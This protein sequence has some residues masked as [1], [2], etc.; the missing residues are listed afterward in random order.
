MSEW[1]ETADEY[2]EYLKQLDEWLGT[3]RFSKLPK[4]VQMVIARGQIT[5]EEKIEKYEEWAQKENQA[6]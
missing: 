3:I 5:F 4:G 6:E 1:Q 2:K